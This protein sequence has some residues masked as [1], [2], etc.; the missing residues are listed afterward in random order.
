MRCHADGQLAVQVVFT[1]AKE[2]KIKGR[3]RVLNLHPIGGGG[4]APPAVFD[5]RAQHRQR[6]PR[7]NPLYGVHQTAVGQAIGQGQQQIAGP[8]DAQTFKALRY[9]WADAGQ[10]GQVRKQREQDFGAGCSWCFEQWKIRRRAAFIG[11][12]NARQGDPAVFI[13]CL[14]AQISGFLCL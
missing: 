14:N 10:G 3:R 6:L 4:G 1:G 7:W 9:F 11:V 13:D 5:H 2:H 8:T 12:S